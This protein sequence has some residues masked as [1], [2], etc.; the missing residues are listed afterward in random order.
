MSEDAGTLAVFLLLALT[1][2]FF[3]AVAACRTGPGRGWIAGAG[4]CGFAGTVLPVVQSALETLG[5]TGLF[6]RVPDE[7]AGAMI[8]GSFSLFVGA[9]VLL[10]VG[11]LKAWRDREAPAGPLHD[12]ALDGAAGRG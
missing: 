8:L 12:A 6:S 9:Q 2:P 4:L 10:L 1:Y 11:L 3:A 5:L 7:I